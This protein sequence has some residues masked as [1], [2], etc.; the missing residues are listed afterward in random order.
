LEQM[1]AH[2]TDLM[3]AKEDGTLCPRQKAEG[4]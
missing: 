2:M 1:R 3:H 4:R